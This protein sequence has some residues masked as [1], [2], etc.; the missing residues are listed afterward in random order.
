MPNLISRCFAL[1]IG[2]LFMVT[3]LSA[4]TGSPFGV[5]AHAAKD[6]EWPQIDNELLKCQQAGI[7]WLRV[8]IQFS[9]VCAVAGQ[10]E[11]TRYDSLLLKL[12]QYGI[13]WLPIL[14]GFD[15]EISKPRPDMVPLYNH[16]PEWRAFVQ[17]VV[18]RYHSHTKY[19]E[20]WN[21]EDGGFWKPNPNAA[22]YVP[23]LKASYEEIKAIDTSCSV[24]V[25]GLAGWNADYLSGMYAAG[26]KGYF[27]KIAVHPYGYGIDNSA[28]TT[29]L[30][31][32]FNTVLQQNGQA[33]MPIWITESGGSSFVA[34]TIQ[35]QPLFAVQAI[36][37]A[38][39][40]LGKD[41]TTFKVGI[42]VSP[43]ITNLDEVETWRSWLPGITLVPIPFSDLATLD[44]AEFPVLLGSESTATDQPM[45]N[46][47][48]DYVIRGGLMLAVNILPFY[49]TNVQNPD[50]TWSSTGAA[51]YNYPFFRIGF[52]ASWTKPGIPAST[53]NISVTP[54]ALAGGVPALSNVLVDRFISP[55]NL[56]PTDTYY[57]IVRCFNSSNVNVGE[58]MS[59]FTYGDWKGGILMGTAALTGGYSV[60]E[61]ANLLQRVYLSY[62]SLGVEKIFW[63]DLHSDNGQPADKEGNFGL[64]KWDFSPKPAYNSYKEMTGYLGAEP[65]FL[66]RISAANTQVWALAFRKKED[67]TNILAM[68]S[69]DS[70]ASYQVLH[71]DT[72]MGTWKGNK[73]YFIPLTDSVNAYKII[74]PGTLQMDS[75]GVKTYGD[76]DFILNATS[77]NKLLPVSFSNRNAAVAKV[78]QDSTAG[79]QWKVKILGAGTDTLVATQWDLNN[80]PSADSTLRPLVVSPAVISITPE[81]TSKIYG[82]ANPFFTARYTGF[83]YNDDTTVITRHPDLSSTA[84]QWSVPGQYPI[85]ASGGA[86]RNYIFQYHQGTLQVEAA[87]SKPKNSSLVSLF[88]GSNTVLATVLTPYE[89]KALFEIVD[90][91]GRRVFAQNINLHKG[92]NRLQF[93]VQDVV[94]GFYVGVVGTALW[95]MTCKM[96]K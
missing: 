9:R 17:A 79:G 14:Q 80:Y 49:Y 25:G 37:Y 1:C 43:R 41:T 69:A 7:K 29:R 48:R 62:L 86:A 4:Q 82:R 36:K 61:Q 72:V 10:Y 83:M 3:S 60:N 46:P 93:Q 58:A 76:T 2:M 81:D 21:E 84:T 65:R 39:N 85:T 16:L 44:P 30:R 57:P 42:A 67:S 77:S 28:R 40:K 87:P 59:L 35:K 52:E 91:T 92:I 15:T 27:D 12:Q 24:I 94:R 38:L 88:L 96:V 32:D 34:S 66:K 33:N 19:W 56:Q 73:V 78:Y 51:S 18:N 5:C 75:V 6:P 23:L 26:A 68:W 50:G 64:L 54:D 55:K 74:T 70:A 53:T 31:N 71:R 95:S 47:L 8:D 45:L 90:L 63:Y 13:Q 11:F 89:G 22:Q 20:I